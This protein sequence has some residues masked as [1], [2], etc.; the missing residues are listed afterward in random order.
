VSFRTGAGGIWFFPARRSTLPRMPTLVLTLIVVYA[1]FFVLIHAI[2][3]R[4]KP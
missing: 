3:A 4:P 1:V 2:V